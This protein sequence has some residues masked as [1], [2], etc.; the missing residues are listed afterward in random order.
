MPAAEIRTKRW[1]DPVEPE[2]GTRILICRYR[3]RAL[4]KSEETWTEWHPNLGPSKELHAA[5]YGKNRAQP[6]DWASYRATYLREMREQKDAIA[7]L[8]ERVKNGERITLLCS[9][10]CEREARCH[11]SLLRELILKKC[12][13]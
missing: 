7:Q 10:A 6:L 2:D 5:A 11:R 12:E 1:N 3:P 4:P 9:S 13:E 8:A